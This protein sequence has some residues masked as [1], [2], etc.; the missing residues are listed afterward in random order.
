MTWIQRVVARLFP[1][2][3]THV[4]TLEGAA[5][6]FWLL[7]DGLHTTREIATALADVPQAEARAERFVADLARR[8]YLV[9]GN[10]PSPALDTRRGLTRE[11]GYA[12]LPCRRCKRRQPMLLVDSARWYCPH[13][14]KLNRA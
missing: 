5:A 9:V 11:R 6:R 4:V 8:G 7:C 13:C 12:I 10:A 1:L 3:G 14:R 2:G